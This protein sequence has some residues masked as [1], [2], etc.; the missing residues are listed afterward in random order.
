MNRLTYSLRRSILMECLSKVT[1]R[2]HIHADRSR[3]L[4]D[5]KMGLVISTCPVI[6][7]WDM[8]AGHCKVRR[9]VSGSLFLGYWRLGINVTI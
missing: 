3:S 5:T 7:P 6:A 9:M 8:A 4:S 1:R 2:V